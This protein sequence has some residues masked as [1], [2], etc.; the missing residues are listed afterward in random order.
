MIFKLITLFSIL[1]FSAAVTADNKNPDVPPP[2]DM[3]A[4][5]KDFDE[6]S[7]IK[8][9][10]TIHKGKQKVIEEYRINGQLYMIRVIPKIGKPYYIRYTDGTS[11][12][13]IRRE[14]DDINMP[15]WK[16][17]EW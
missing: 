12:Q 6:Q 14:L 11:G 10:V 16:L 8:A 17:F 7:S 15:F 5:F 1:S 3:P 13:A 2:P 9:D 4:D